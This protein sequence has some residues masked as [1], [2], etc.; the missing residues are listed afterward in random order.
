MASQHAAEHQPDAE[1]VSRY[2]APLNLG[3]GG[4]L[5]GIARF[6]VLH[7]KQCRQWL[8]TLAMANVCQV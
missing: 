7:G 4:D 2:A 8:P 3:V 6:A 5:R 1:G